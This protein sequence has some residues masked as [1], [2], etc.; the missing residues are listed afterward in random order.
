MT[1]LCLA[2]RAS[3]S[4]VM[5]SQSCPRDCTAPSTMASRLQAWRWLDSTLAQLETSIASCYRPIPTRTVA[6]NVSKFIWCILS[7]EFDKGWACRAKGITA[8]IDFKPF[9][10]ERLPTDVFVSALPDP[11]RRS[12]HSKGKREL[13]IVHESMIHIVL[14]IH[15]MLVCILSFILPHMVP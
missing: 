5:S 12:K 10:I 11:A 1:V 4:K 2:A 8:G 15:I 13:G 3:N 7:T 14:V 6:I 9:L